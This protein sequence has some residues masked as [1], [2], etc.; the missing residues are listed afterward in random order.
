MVDR[1]EAYSH[2]FQSA[3]R[4]LRYVDYA[5]AERDCETL[6]E[7][8]VA[9]VGEETLRTAHFAG[10]PRGGLIVLGMLSYVLDLDH[11]Q[12]EGSPPPYAPI[13]VV[14][15]CALTGHRFHQFIQRY[16]DREIIFAPLYSH[17]DLRVAIEQEEPNV[18]ACV[19]AQDL[20][21][22]APDEVDDYEA[23]KERWRNRETGKRYWTGQPDH[24]C[25][26]WNEPDI[27][28]W[29]SETEQVERGPRV[30]PPEYCLKNRHALDEESSIPVQVQP[31]PAG[32]I[33]PHPS[34]FFGT[35][36]E[37]TIVAK[38]D[39]DV[40]VEIDGTAADM[41]HALVEHGTVEDVLD[42]LLETYDVDRATLRADLLDFMNDLAAHDL[43]HIPDAVDV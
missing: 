28:V 7:H 16:L 25:F 24:I 15:D 9:R 30:V 29:N 42:A 37:S 4:R 20:H 35:L 36:D 3:L 18:T 19:S 32:P 41:W 8:L 39:S 31:E 40:C 21:D 10:I 6:A 23:W 17:P 27:G 12:L 1:L 38:P 11:E 2:H 5:Q 22:H 26:P 14:D 33:K 13:V 43:L 34:V